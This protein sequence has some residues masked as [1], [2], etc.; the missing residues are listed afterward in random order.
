MHRATIQQRVHRFSNVKGAA[1]PFQI[2]QFG[3]RRSAFSPNWV[4]HTWTCIQ[5]I[6]WYTV[7]DACDYLFWLYFLL[8]HIIFFILNLEFWTL[9]MVLKC[10]LSLRWRSNN[11]K[12]E[13]FACTFLKAA[14]GKSTIASL[15]LISE[16]SELFTHILTRKWNHFRNFFIKWILLVRTDKLIHL[17]YCLT[18][19]FSLE[20]DSYVTPRWCPRVL[21]MQLYPRLS[22]HFFSY[23]Y[24]LP[25]Q[26]WLHTI[27]SGHNGWSLLLTFQLFGILCKYKS[28]S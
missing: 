20:F 15:L 22:E 2:G 11:V 6:V 9:W 26:L 16:Y 5:P 25:N 3:L 28:S 18:S 7:L 13:W 1:L 14:L 10:V 24:L 4:L 23:P 27:R 17:W 12:P 19:N 8:C 21:S